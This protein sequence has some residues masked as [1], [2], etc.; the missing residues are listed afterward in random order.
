MRV[1]E[2]DAAKEQYLNQTIEQ[3][4]QNAQVQQKQAPAAA[5]ANGAAAADAIVEAG[6]VT[7]AQKMA[8]QVAIANASTLEEVHRLEKALKAGQMPEGE[9]AAAG[10]VQ[11]SEAQDAPPGTDA[12]E[13]G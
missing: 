7:E 12:M 5:P 8:I 4:Q 13:E 11:M 10:D 9:A 2:R 3:V 1:Q 6:T